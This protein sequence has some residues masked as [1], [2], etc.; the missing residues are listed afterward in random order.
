MRQ[1]DSMKAS[2]A[3]K[4]KAAK[5]ASDQ[6]RDVEKLM[7]DMT[8]VRAKFLKQCD[9]D[10]IKEIKRVMAV[11]VSPVCNTAREILDKICQFLDANPD[12]SFSNQGTTIFDS[13]ESFNSAC[14]S[15]DPAAMEKA[16]IQSVAESVNMS[17]DGVKG[18]LLI[19][20]SDSTTSEAML[21]FFPYFKVLYKLCQMGMTL[22][23]KQSLE[24]KAENSKKEMD[25][26]NIE[27]VT[28]QAIVDNLAFHERMT[29]EAGRTRQEELAALMRKERA[30]ANKI[31]ELQLYKDEARFREQYFR[32]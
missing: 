6:L 23:K 30:L 10:S 29:A 28:A 5:D 8:E 13:A 7:T 12:A 18:R 9:K 27:Q 21:P 1:L 16:F 25:E 22:K 24:R 2:A 31:Q 17:L 3:A 20:V 4:K 19:L 32:N 26:L 11:G 14:K 15:C